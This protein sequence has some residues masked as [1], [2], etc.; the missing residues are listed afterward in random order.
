[1][2]YSTEAHKE[3]SK[4]IESKSFSKDYHNY[5]KQ[6]EMKCKEIYSENIPSL[7]HPVILPNETLLKIFLQCEQMNRV[8]NKTT[9]LYKTNSEVKAFFNL[10]D[11]LTN[12]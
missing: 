4:Y 3:I 9:E 12:G 2:L 5:F 7:F 6:I 11:P 1:M 10:P 8:L